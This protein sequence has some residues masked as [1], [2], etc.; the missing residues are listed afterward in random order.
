MVCVT[1]DSTS[2]SDAGAGCLGVQDQM[3]QRRA[4]LG[5]IRTPAVC[6]E[7]G[8]SSRETPLSSI[9]EPKARKMQ[10]LHTSRTGP[11]QATL[12]Q[13]PPGPP[14]H[15]C[16]HRPRGSLCLDSE[17]R[18]PAQAPAP[19]AAAR[20]EQTPAFVINLSSEPL[21]GTALIINPARLTINSI[22]LTFHHR[23]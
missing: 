7:R 6:R 23:V 8:R 13:R 17:A 21:P 14:Q 22:D 10:M 9:S 18:P 12:S 20:E 4:E 5:A 2:C 11:Q 3:E 16:P 1:P 15:F 19:H